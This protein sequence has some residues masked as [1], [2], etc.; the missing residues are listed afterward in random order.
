MKFY[1]LGFKNK[2][3]TLW[4][5]STQTVKVNDYFNRELNMYKSVSLSENISRDYF[6]WLT[7]K[8]G[9]QSFTFSITDPFNISN[10]RF[11]LSLIYNESKC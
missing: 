3:S 9:I 5:R 4:K 1:L 2:K 7:E 8:V 6:N 10:F 11:N